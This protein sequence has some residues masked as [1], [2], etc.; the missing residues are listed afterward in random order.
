MPGRK[1]NGTEI[2]G[3]EFPQISIYLTRLS[4]FQENAGKYCSIRHWKFPE[5]QTGVLG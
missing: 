1:S 3:K 2:P 4:S 5:I